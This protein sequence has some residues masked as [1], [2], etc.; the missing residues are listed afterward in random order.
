MNCRNCNAEISKN[1]ICCPYCGTPQNNMSKQNY[2]SHTEC[3]LSML[4]HS[5][6]HYVDFK[7][8]S[9]RTEYWIFITFYL[10]L[11]SIC[12]CIN[13][14]L[15]LIF[16]LATAIPLFAVSIRRMRD[17][18]YFPWIPFILFGVY[19]LLSLIWYISW[20]G[21]GNGIGNIIGQALGMGRSSG[22]S[23]IKIYIS[24]IGCTFFCMI[25]IAAF[26]AFLASRPT[27]APGQTRK[28][29]GFT[30]LALPPAG[31]G[32]GQN[33]PQWQNSQPMSGQPMPSQPMPGQPM[34]SQPMPSQ[35]MPGQPMPGQPMPGQPMPGQPMPGQPMPG[36][37][38]SGQPMSGQP[39]SGQPMPTT[40]YTTIQNGMNTTQFKSENKQ[41]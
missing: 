11:L 17:A 10:F 40:P 25:A 41:N 21:L 36:Q 29:F 7:G 31:Y 26:I 32:I 39:I 13:E 18:G 2:A 22:D 30:R 3:A 27:A 35:P 19:A 12:S 23:N 28:I 1:D 34:S 14:W 4:K 20:D 37:P 15:A 33:P 16:E 6:I 38:M 24:L 9:S 8:I 5:F